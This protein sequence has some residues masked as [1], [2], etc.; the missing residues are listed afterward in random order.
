MEAINSMFGC[1]QQQKTRQRISGIDTDAH[2]WVRVVE[3]CGSTLD[4]FNFLS[5][6]RSKIQV[7]SKVGGRVGGLRRK[8]YV[9]ISNLGKERKLLR[10]HGM[11]VGQQ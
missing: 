9:M 1:L 5:G 4:Y 7:E 3:A 2:R 8:E 11:I 6:I 10:K